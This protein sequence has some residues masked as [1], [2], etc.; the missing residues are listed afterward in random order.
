MTFASLSGGRDSTAMVVKWLENGNK[1]DYILFCDTYYEHD[2]MYTYIDNLEKYLLN[3]FNMQLTRIDSGDII[4]ELMWSPFKKGEKKGIIRGLPFSYH[5]DFCTLY[6]KIRPSAKF[7]KEHCANKFRA[8]M[9]IGYT[10]NEVERGRNT[11]LDYAIAEYPLH[12]WKMNEPE[13][14]AFLVERGIANPLYRHFK[15]TGCFICP[16]QSK[17]DLW[18]IYKYYPQK[19]QIM[20]EMEAKAKELNASNQTFKYKKS[21]AEFEK[22]FKHTQELLFDNEYE[23]NETCFCR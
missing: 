21:L 20:K 4:T 15:R 17:S 8:K 10:Y 16:N 14:E 5:R 7:V 11:N 3:K 18:H 12:E 23:A 6:S 13:C 9:L 2:E 22:E 1:L 19:W